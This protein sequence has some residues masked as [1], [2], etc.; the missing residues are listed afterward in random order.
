MI[1]PKELWLADC[2]VNSALHMV[3]QTEAAFISAKARHKRERDKATALRLKYNAERDTERDMSEGVTPES[4]PF[5]IGPDGL[6][7]L[8]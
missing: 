8:D 6:P 3:E 2:V 7:Q 4:Y 5:S 1:D